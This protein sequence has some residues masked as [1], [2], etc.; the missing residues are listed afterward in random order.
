MYD[1]TLSIDLGA[2]YTKI[3]YRKACA[4]KQ[5]GPFEQEARI[6]MVDNSPLIPSL[7]VRT[8]NAS[9][10]WVFGREAANLNPDRGMEV[11]Q[12]WKADLFRPR[13]DKDSAAAVMVA[14]KFFEWLRTKLE[15]ARIDLK[16][17]ETRVA[18]PAFHSSAEKAVFIARCLD[19]SGW[20][21]PSLILK[22]TEP[23]ANTIG[24]FSRG[25]NAGSRNG[26]GELLLNYGRMFG[27]GNVYVQASR[28]FV[29]HGTRGN[30]V[31]V[32]VVD[33]GAFTTDIAALTF[34]VTSPGNEMGDGLSAI[35]QEESYELGVINELDRPLFD[36]LAQRHGFTWSDVSFNDRELLKRALYN[37]EPYFLLTRSDG[38]NVSLELGGPEDT[39]LVTAHASTFAAAVWEKVMAFVETEKPARVF[40]TGGGSLIRPVAA[41]LGTSLSRR[42]VTLGVVDRGESAGGATEWRSWAQTGEGL[43]RLATALGG[44]SVILQAGSALRQGRAEILRPRPPLLVAA[45]AGFKTCRCQGSNKDCC[46]CGGRGCA[47]G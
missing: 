9:K 20:D 11:F 14:G 21:D 46:F 40:L 30:L 10:P 2:S 39:E 36:A 18:M 24:L 29:L 13:N 47:K 35:R 45:D 1:A 34:D 22:V 38:K 17:C 43:Q 19:L 23:H 37:G 16:K 42:Q 27:Q 33:I 31:T 7:A 4:P 44:A 6:L 28:E 25:K 8:R 12:N 26:A 3:A 5:T 15:A 41:A 32:L